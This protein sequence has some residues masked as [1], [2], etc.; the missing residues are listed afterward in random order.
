MVV[1][2]RTRNITGRYYSKRSGLICSTA[3][4]NGHFGHHPCQTWAALPALTIASRFKFSLIDDLPDKCII[5]FVHCL[6]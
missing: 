2:Q 5:W 3:V 1:M 4:D 6:S